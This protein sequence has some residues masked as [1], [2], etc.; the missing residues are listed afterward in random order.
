[1]TGDMGRCLCSLIW[2]SKHEAQRV[3]VG[4]SLLN[5]SVLE[6]QALAMG[7]S[8]LMCEQGFGAY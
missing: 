7:C 3:P 2:L 8:Y 5:Q 6:C 4:L 1:M